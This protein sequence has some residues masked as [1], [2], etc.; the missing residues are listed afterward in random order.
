MNKKERFK[1]KL[2]ENFSTII[3]YVR[4]SRKK[5][6]NDEARPM[7]RHTESLVFLL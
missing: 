6:F 4:F 2:C 5:K 3:N 1:E 7:D